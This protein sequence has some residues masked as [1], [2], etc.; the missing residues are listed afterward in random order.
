MVTQ[1]DTSHIGVCDILRKSNIINIISK[2]SL[3]YQINETSSYK[4]TSVFQQ[5]ADPQANVA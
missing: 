5:D 4:H 1:L 3:K 2:L